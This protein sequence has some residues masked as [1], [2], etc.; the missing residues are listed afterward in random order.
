MAVLFWSPQTGH[1]TGT[2]EAII[3]QLSPFVGVPIGGHDSHW[4]P[5]QVEET[6]TYGAKPRGKAS[7][8]HGAPW[9]LPSDVNMRVEA[10]RSWPLGQKDY[11]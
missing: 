7:L 10:T 9:K 2:P 1:Q 6:K 3:A 4:N 11:D 5:H 8:D